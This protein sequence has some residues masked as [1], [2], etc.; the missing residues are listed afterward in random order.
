MLVYHSG[1]TPF[2]ARTLSEVRV[3]VVEFIC[4]QLL[5][6]CHIFHIPRCHDFHR[7]L[8][9]ITIPDWAAGYATSY[10]A[11]ILIQDRRA[12]RAA[13]LP[14]CVKWCSFSRNCGQTARFSFFY[15]FIVGLCLV[16]YLSVFLF[17]VVFVLVSFCFP[18]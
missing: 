16:Y 18:S 8:R 9:G 1:G 6:S 11:G 3:S 13:L 2:F 15:I 17:F 7:W 14:S 5:C 10:M 12:S 4:D